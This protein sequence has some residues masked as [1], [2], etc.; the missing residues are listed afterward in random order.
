MEAVNSS[1]LLAEVTHVGLRVDRPGADDQLERLARRELAAVA[2][3]V[4]SKPVA[5]RAELAALEVVVEARDVREHAL[6]DLGRDQVAERVGREVAD[7]AAGPV[8]V[9]EDAAAVV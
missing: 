2:V 1:D 7:R 3:E 6:P 8:G 9:L 4:L 5:E